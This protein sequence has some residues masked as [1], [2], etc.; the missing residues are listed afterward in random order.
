L[1]NFRVQTTAICLS[2]GVAASAVLFSL[3]SQDAASKPLQ[4]DPMWRQAVAA[5]ADDELGPLHYVAAAEAA[6]PG[7]D[8]APRPATVS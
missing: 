2:I 1:S 6:V 3:P 8:I 5:G 7:A 4:P